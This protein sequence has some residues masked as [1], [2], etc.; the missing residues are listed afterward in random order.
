[1]TNYEPFGKVIGGTPKDGP[2]Y[3]GHVLDTATGLNYMQQ[4]Y[5]DP[6]IGRFLSVDPVTADGNTGANFN[7]Y[8]YANNNP[9][10]FT[11]PDG[12]FPDII[13]DIAFIVADVVDIASNGLNAT[14]GASL[15]GNLLGAAIPGA[16][17]LGK[18]AAAGVVAVKAADGAKD[19]N[20]IASK[21]EDATKPGS[22][23]N[24][25]TD[26]TKAEFEGNLVNN[27]FTQSASKD[28][29]VNVFE[30]GD[31]K[32]TTRDSSKSG[33]PTAES[34][35]DGALTVKIRLDENL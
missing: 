18:V 23:P 7:R 12:R 11:D 13:L 19:A 14:N 29:K 35:K 3:T 8:W 16:T 30:K 24:I 15:A 28:G 20:R 31:Q 33:G 34:F 25:K 9:Y 2:G 32:L 22:I 27:G 6:G 21:V 4:R 26:V 1:R 10:K 17:G 5:Y